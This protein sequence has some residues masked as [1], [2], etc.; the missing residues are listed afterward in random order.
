MTLKF[1]FLIS[2]AAA[3]PAAPDPIITTSALYCLTPQHLFL[4]YLI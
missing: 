1:A 4:I 2:I 3:N